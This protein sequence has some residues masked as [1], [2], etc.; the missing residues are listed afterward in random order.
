MGGF[1]NILSCEVLHYDNCI[2]WSHSTLGQLRSRINTPH[3][4]KYATDDQFHVAI[5]DFFH[6]SSNTQ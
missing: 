2:I 3:K 4:D 5:F 6:N 1:Y